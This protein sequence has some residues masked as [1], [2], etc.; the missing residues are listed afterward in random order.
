MTTITFVTTKEAWRRIRRIA[1]LRYVASQ[2]KTM[3]AD[4]DELDIDCLAL[5]G[6]QLYVPALTTLATRLYTDETAVE[7]NR[8]RRRSQERL[9]SFKQSLVRRAPLLGRSGV[10]NEDRDTSAGVS[11]SGSTVRQ[12]D[13][14][15]SP[16]GSNLRISYGS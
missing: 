1:R 12:R 13:A 2:S 7:A 15:S 5:F 6:D 3:M 16:Y 4:F 8:R 10:G 9:Q 11:D 14:G